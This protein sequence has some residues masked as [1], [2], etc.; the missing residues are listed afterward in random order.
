MSTPKAY[1][2]CLQLSLTTPLNRRAHQ[3][4]RALAPKPRTR[5]ETR[6]GDERA[7]ALREEDDL[8]DLPVHHRCPSGVD[9]FLH[10]DLAGLT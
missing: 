3:R 4:S 1:E 7:N 10:E 5:K 8:R 6:D 9:D 2:A